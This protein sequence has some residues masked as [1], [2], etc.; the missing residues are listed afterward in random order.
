M[1][2]WTYEVLP[3]LDKAQVYN[4]EDRVNPIDPVYVIP[5]RNRKD[6]MSYFSSK[7]GF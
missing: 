5:E 6:I 3:Y 4:E 1:M 2:P 7:P